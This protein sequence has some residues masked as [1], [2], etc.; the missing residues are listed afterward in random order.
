MLF[1]LISTTSH[2]L[3][4]F[5]FCVMLGDEYAQYGWNV[6]VSAFLFKT[7]EFIHLFKHLDF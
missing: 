6:L 2:L 3:V 4:L 7:L 1:K 5:F